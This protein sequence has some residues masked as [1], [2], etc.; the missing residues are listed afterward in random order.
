MEDFKPYQR[1]DSHVI[2]NAHCIYRVYKIPGLRECEYYD[3]TGIEKTYDL[4]ETDS[5]YPPDEDAVPSLLMVGKGK[6]SRAVIRKNI[7]HTTAVC[8]E[9]D[10]T[11]VVDPDKKEKFCP[12]CGLILGRGDEVDSDALQITPH[13][14]REPK[15]SERAYE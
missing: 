14:M 13:L 5:E 8:P 10:V 7:Q 6:G 12:E 4:T 15:D 11:G 2:E 3:G 1:A 9:C